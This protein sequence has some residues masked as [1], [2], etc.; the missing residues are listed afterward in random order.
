MALV[1]LVSERKSRHTAQTYHVPA[2][3][4]QAELS[5]IAN[6][7][8]CCV[9]AAPFHMTCCHRQGGCIRTQPQAVL[10]C[11]AIDLAESATLV[12]R[13]FRDSSSRGAGNDFLVNGH[14][15]GTR[16]LFVLARNYLRHDLQHFA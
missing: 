13:R 11:G 1:S 4:S 9:P 14:D 15:T 5:G 10:A 2:G 16:T 3:K 8:S 7:Y 12:I 6:V